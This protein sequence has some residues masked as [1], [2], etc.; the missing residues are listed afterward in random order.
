MPLRLPSSAHG[1]EAVR[2]AREPVGGG[3][4][5]RAERLER[6]DRAHQLGPRGR[7]QPAGGTARGVREQDR[8]PDAVDELGAELALDRVGGAQVGGHRAAA[9][10]HVEDR[11]V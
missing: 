3:A 7:D 4:K 6:D 2:E 9:G 8:R 10:D 5:R 11:R 1:G